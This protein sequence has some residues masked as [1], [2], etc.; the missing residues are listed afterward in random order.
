MGITKIASLLLLTSCAGPNLWTLDT[1]ATGE[2]AFNSAKI[3]HVDLN[4]SPLQFEVVS[5]KAGVA[6]FLKLTKYQFTSSQEYP[7]MVEAFVSIDG[8]KF[9]EILPILE[10]RM[11]LR[12][13]QQLT[14][15]LTRALQDGKKIDIFLDG[16]GQTLPSEGFSKFYNMFK[17]PIE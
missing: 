12:L 1:L 13:P 17:G 9:T 5:T 7:G 3:S 14:D 2:K 8:E 11:C 4:H 10:G 15:R 6:S 16:F